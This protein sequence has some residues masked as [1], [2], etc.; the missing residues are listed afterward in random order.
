MGTASLADRGDDRRFARERRRLE[1]DEVRRF[2][3]R[4][5]TR[6]NGL[7]AALGVLLFVAGFVAFM[8]WSPT[9]V[10]REIRIT[11]LDRIPEPE[12]QA[13]LA[14]LDGVPLAQVG[15]ADI[16]ARLEPIVLVQSYALEVVPPSTIV[17]SIVERT[18]VGVVASPDGFVAVD[19]AGVPLWTEAEPPADLPEIKSGGTQQ[20]GFEPA[21][22]VSLALPEDFRMRIATIDATTM[23]DVKL[24]MR[25]GTTVVWGSS[26]DSERKAKVLVALMAAT[27]NGANTYDV[28]SPDTPITR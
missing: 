11:G 7:V 12:V 1:R 28:S 19:A 13:A 9:T 3:A 24:T 27:E 16:G 25:D 14:D 4:R 20:P 21:A 5:R 2:T 15:T 26:D 8:I 10:I 18:P 17:V 23:D 6:R 22:G